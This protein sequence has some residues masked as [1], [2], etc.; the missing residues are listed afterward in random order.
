MILI[1][2]LFFFQLAA[3][4]VVKSW[5]PGKSADLVKFVS[6]S[7]LKDFVPVNEQLV[8]WGG[9]INYQFV[10]EPEFLPA[11]GSVAINGQ[12]YDD[13]RKKVRKKYILFI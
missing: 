10:F 9:Q 11:T 1:F 12:Q 8:E 3:W 6:R 2:S 7:D 4:K 13:A 5:M